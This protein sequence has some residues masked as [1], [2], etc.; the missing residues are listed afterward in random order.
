[1]STKMPNMLTNTLNLFQCRMKND[2]SRMGS[3]S[4]GF[5]VIHVTRFCH[6]MAI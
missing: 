4:D 3:R 6:E 5:N 2:W 1:M